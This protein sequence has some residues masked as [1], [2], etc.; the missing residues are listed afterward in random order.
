[1]LRNKI[2]NKL[3]RNSKS[4]ACGIMPDPDDRECSLGLEDSEVP[5]A[6]GKVRFV[7]GRMGD[8]PVD[9]TSDEAD[10]SI[11]DDLVAVD[12]Y[13][14]EEHIGQHPALKTVCVIDTLTEKR[15]IPNSNQS[16]ALDN[17]CF[18]GDVMLLMRTPDVD[19]PR[20]EGVELGQTQQK[21]SEYFRGKKRRFEFQF[22]IRLKKVPRG[23]L[24]LGCELEHCVKVGT[25]TKGLVGILLSIIRRINPGFHYS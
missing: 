7:D 1:M 4:L 22:Q 10:S 11:M 19:N 23:A 25:L 6:I 3:S 5:A 12:E 14:D 9:E 18:E 16:F 24:F 21:V 20:E 2:K 15:I 8:S 13:E 17:E